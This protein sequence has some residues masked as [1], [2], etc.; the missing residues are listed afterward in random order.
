MRFESERPREEQKCP[1]SLWHTFCN[2][3]HMRIETKTGDA[4][5]NGYA[6]GFP[7]SGK[8]ITGSAVLSAV[9]IVAAAALGLLESRGNA[10]EHPGRVSLSNITT[11]VEQNESAPDDLSLN[12]P[13]DPSAVRVSSHFTDQTGPS[14]R[15][16][17]EKERETLAFL[18]AKHPDNPYIPDPSARSS[19]MDPRMVE[20]RKQGRALYAEMV[21][22]PRP[23]AVRAFYHAARTDLNHQ[24]QWF[25]LSIEH[26]LNT[27]FPAGMSRDQFRRVVLERFYRKIDS[28]DVEE[29]RALEQK[30]PG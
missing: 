20:F 28:L 18:R 23:S 24:M 22:N 14:K 30:R 9:V 21:S 10:T 19:E 26:G 17:Q 11:A 6:R 25:E 8:V 29:S 27:E 2:R 16:Q 5:R 15:R 13:E 3:S 4:Y 1:K 7:R 12:D